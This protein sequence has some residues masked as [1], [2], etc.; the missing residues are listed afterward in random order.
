MTTVGNDVLLNSICCF[1]L[2]MQPLLESKF[3]AF[4]APFKKGAQRVKA[5]GAEIAPSSVQRVD[6]LRRILLRD[7]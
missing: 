1:P 4:V 5:D 2:N 6:T 7:L 3:V